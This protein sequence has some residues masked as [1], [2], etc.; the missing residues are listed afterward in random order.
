MAP[1]FVLTTYKANSGAIRV[2]EWGLISDMTSYLT[3]TTNGVKGIA[4]EN[5]A[6]FDSFY[7]EGCYSRQLLR[8]A[9]TWR[10]G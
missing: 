8:R 6:L 7:S 9:K 4:V 5:P 2:I 3:E 10:N 1:L